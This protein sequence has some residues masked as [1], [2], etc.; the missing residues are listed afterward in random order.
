MF[1]SH[2]I[3]VVL[4]KYS[5]EFIGQTWQIWKTT[6]KAKQEKKKKI[7]EIFTYPSK[8]L[9]LRFEESFILL[10]KVVRSMPPLCP[11]KSYSNPNSQYL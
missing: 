6:Y 9:D 11:P 3:I 4:E 1:A 2:P 5:K 7:S 10:D 8:I